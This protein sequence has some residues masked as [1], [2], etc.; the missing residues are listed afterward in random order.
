MVVVV[1]LDHHTFLTEPNFLNIVR[2]I[3]P[4]M[5]VAVSR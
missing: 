3:T 2:Q 5:I 1:S 4:L